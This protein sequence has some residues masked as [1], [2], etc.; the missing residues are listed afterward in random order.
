LSEQSAK[1]KKGMALLTKM[2]RKDTMLFQKKHY[3]E[4]YELSVG[5]LFGDIW[6]RPHLSLRDRQLITLASNISMARPT[7]THSHFRSAQEIGVSKEEIMELIIHVGAYTGW[8]TM[9][10]ALYQFN[11]VC[12]ED[13]AKARKTKA[14]KAKKTKK[15]TTK[16]ATV[17][18]EKL[19]K[20]PAKKSRKKK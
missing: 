17:K 8:P 9:A 3:P 10:H 12:E 2:G 5:H 11:E 1:F 14:K 15:A 6:H 7:G 4:L 19:K 16:K 13:A 18:K 20:A